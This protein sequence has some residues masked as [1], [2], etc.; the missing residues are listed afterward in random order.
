[1]QRTGGG[2]VANQKIFECLPTADTPITVAQSA[3]LLDK[4]AAS[5][6]YTFLPKAARLKVDMSREKMA[7]MAAGGAPKSEHLVASP[8]MKDLADRLQFFCR[9][10]L[11]S[12]SGAPTVL[13]G[14]HALGH[15][16]KEAQQKATAGGLTRS[17]SE[18][19]HIF[20]H[21]I[22]TNETR[23]LSELTDKVMESVKCLGPKKRAPTQ[24]QATNSSNSR[25]KRTAKP[26]ADT[27]K[28]LDLFA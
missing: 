23:V 9:A 12:E 25:G 7:E 18:V 5:D 19:F 10:E 3:T 17:G 21:M 11:V 28:V 15:L 20:Q 24:P 6:V 26:Q 13:T 4:L 22:D 27:G 2:G 1:M 8:F 14:K 16:L